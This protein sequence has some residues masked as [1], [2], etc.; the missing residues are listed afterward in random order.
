MESDIEKISKVIRE[1]L[2]EKVGE[3]LKQILEEHKKFKEKCENLTKTNE[4]LD[5]TL[6]E[7]KKELKDVKQ[8]FSDFKEAAGDLDKREA[9]LK[10]EQRDLKITILE[11]KLDS[12]ESVSDNYK[13]FMLAIARNTGF[14]KQVFKDVAFPVE[15]AQ[16]LVDSNGCVVQ[17]PTTGSIETKMV[18][19]TET[20][21][22]E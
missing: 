8:E 1:S 9:D 11:S 15:G 16:G 3:E 7:T 21:T 13:N 19:E 22:E 17:Y 6:T 10:E 18:S 2:P 14:R 20:I 4:D 12:A 5:K